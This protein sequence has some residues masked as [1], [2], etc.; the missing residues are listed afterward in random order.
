MTREKYESLSLPALKDLAKARGI[1]GISLMKKVEIVDA[2]L[3]LDA[4]EA[5]A[6]NTKPEDVGSAEEKPKKTL[7]DE[8]KRT[9][10]GEESELSDEKKMLDS[11]EEARGTLEVMSDGYGFIRSENY[12]PGDDDVYVAPSQI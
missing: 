4:K 8:D 1:K 11:G 2:M 7:S 3:A 5:A 10:V 9:A 12:L 6:S